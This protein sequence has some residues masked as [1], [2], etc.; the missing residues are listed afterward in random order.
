MNR[1]KY[2]LVPMIEKVKSFF[3]VPIN[4]LLS[5]QKAFSTIEDISPWTALLWMV[6]ASLF[7]FFLN[8][9][10][11]SSITSSNNIIFGIISSFA[12]IFV[13]FLV[14]VLALSV[15]MFVVAKA[16]GGKCGFWKQTGLMVAYVAPLFILSWFFQVSLVGLLPN[17]TTIII[18]DCFIN[19]VPLAIDLL[20]VLAFSAY[21]YLLAVEAHKLDAKVA[22]VFAAV[23]IAL[24]MLIM[25]ESEWTALFL[26]SGYTSITCLVP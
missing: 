8:R 14:S 19:I 18:S 22:L 25:N 15:A 16:L 12:V 24:M 13:P 20:F 5:P 2:F 7:P 21:S 1:V 3:L 6:V 26:M 17:F 23:P 10:F 11:I 9:N 4:T